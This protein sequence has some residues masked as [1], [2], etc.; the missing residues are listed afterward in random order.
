MTEWRALLIQSLIPAIRGNPFWEEY[1]TDLLS[2]SK[3]SSIHLAVFIEPFLQYVLEGTKEIESRFSA[4]R[5]AP[6]HSVSKGDVVLLKRTGGPVLGLGLVESAWFYELEPDSW[7]E[8]RNNYAT[9]LCAFD[10]LF[11][12]DRKNASFATLMRIEHVHAI[13]PIKVE[14]RDRR[15]WVVVKSA[16]EQMQFLPE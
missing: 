4:V 12:E 10:P 2:S 7:Q 1:L 11:W 8:I 3:S 15:G 13:P 9:A 16:S 5:C 6:Y 14:K